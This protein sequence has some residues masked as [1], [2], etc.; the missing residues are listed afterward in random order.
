MTPE[1]WQQVKNML[2]QALE[3]EPQ[4]RSAFL[5]QR[6][7]ADQSL[8]QEVETLLASE[9][10][11]RS[12]FLDSAA[13]P[14]FLLDEEA[15]FRLPRGK[16]I[17]AFEI[18]EEVAQGGMGAVY[19]AVRADG[20]YK[21][22][23]ALK[24]VRAELGSELTATRFR[25][26][27]Q[28]LATLDHPNIAKILD[29]GSTAEGIPY[30]VMEFI[31]GLPITDYCHRHK[32]SIDARLNLFRTVCS[33]VHYAHQRLVIHRDIKPSNILVAGDG[34]PKLVDFGI[35]KIL[36]PSL[37]VENVTMTGAGWVMT[38]E[39]ASP[40]QLSGAAITTAS[41]VYS[42][43][44]VLYELLTGRRAYRFP[45]R[46]PHEVARIVLES[47]PPKPSTAVRREAE[48]G[49]DKKEKTAL[50]P[51]LVSERRSD[52]PE[53]LERRLAGDLDNIVL[54]AIRKE[55]AARYNS[56]EQFSDD[57][58]RH[59]EGLPVLARKGTLADSGRKF[60][61]RHKVAVTA[62][63]LVL[64]SLIGGMVL[65]LR[66]ARIARAERARAERRFNDLRK[67]AN[68]LMFEIND[69]IRQLPGATAARKLII[70]RAQEYLDSLAQESANDPGLLRELAAAYGKLADVQG[71]VQDANVGDTPGSLQNYRKAI[72]LLESASSLQPSNRE[73][74]RELGQRYLDLS[75]AVGLRAGNKAEYK[76][77]LEKALGILAPLAAVNPEDATT[78][79]ALGVA[80]DSK[81][82]YLRYDNDFP[83]SLDYDG[84]ALTIFERL[85][86]AESNNDLYQAQ[87]SNAHRSMGAVLSIQKQWPAALEQYH[88]AL[89]MDEAQVAR[90]PDSVSARWDLTVSYSNTGFI[91]VR[92]GD[93]DGGL[94]FYLK[95]L[96]IR[97]ELVAAD[98][99]DTRALGGLSQTRTYIAGIY[100]RKENFRRA[101]EYHKEAL[102]I[103]EALLQRDPTSKTARE[104]VAWA[105]A[106]IAQDYLQLAERARSVPDNEL[107]FC[108]E[109]VLWFEPA[110]PIMLHMKSEGRLFGAEREDLETYLR[111]LDK[112]R[113]T[114]ARR[115]ADS[116]P[117]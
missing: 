95:A 99:A 87:I 51:E 40:E 13:I 6:C 65:T 57:L 64:L 88:I 5:A 94:K 76:D 110:L 29:G 22:Q 24:I 17:G 12:G 3:L 48:D 60:V 14:S 115:S 81:A 53:R 102:S 34:I 91:L 2:Q 61:V 42:L 101:I 15:Q 109:C 8:R 35:A 33:A 105:H 36:D 30:F 75:Q 77:I 1:R 100:E 83:G 44:L 69:S 27:R 58:R 84:R 43:G 52:S 107:R 72:A 89:P 73:L 90:H 26:E 62:A 59:L 92:Q 54:K 18:L 80:Y 116:S 31:D 56:A 68:S 19:R 25:N 23:V 39:Y 103:R 7:A 104:V 117:R 97:A 106:E 71:N 67:L 45:S 11:I 21:Q 108:R 63:A 74:R 46:M 112:C 50:A 37:A 82:R 4:E 16:R 79:D 114:I 111:D 47:E 78:Q 113:Q 41:D 98:P 32:L 9:G 49:E 96:K 86:K 55:P 85:A 70:Q 93:L 66:E 10:Q 38:P 28:I 20:L